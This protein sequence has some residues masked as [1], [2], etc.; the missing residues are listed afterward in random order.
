M[1]KISSR[2]ALE[3]HFSLI[4]T[5]ENLTILIV[6]LFLDLQQAPYTYINIFSVTFV[7]KITCSRPLTPLLW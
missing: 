2:I 5:L 4:A 7:H 3:I 1:I 6:S